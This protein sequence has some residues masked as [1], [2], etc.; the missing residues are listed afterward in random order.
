MFF[1]A[2]LLG[3]SLLPFTLPVDAQAV[4]VNIVSDT[5]T[6]KWT[7]SDTNGNPLGSP[8]NVCLNATA[9]SNCPIAATLYGYPS[10]LGGWTADLSTIPGA[11]WIWAP[12]ITGATSPAASAEFSFETQ[13]WLCDTPQGGTISV[14]ADDFAEVFLNGTSILNSTSH[15]TLSTITISS[16]STLVRQGQNFI[17]VKVKN[18]PNPSDCGSGQYQCNPAGVVFGASFQD[19]LSALPTCPAPPP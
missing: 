14:A 6:W 9:P 1:K 10:V 3:V 19:A 2:L 15:S 7:V 16:T 18:G 12:N 8:Q 11:T 17:K 5:T 13:F 4:T